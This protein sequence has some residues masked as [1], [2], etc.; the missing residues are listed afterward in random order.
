ML[1]RT[2]KKHDKY[3]EGNDNQENESDN[4]VPEQAGEGVSKTRFIKAVDELGEDQEDK[5]DDKYAS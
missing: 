1:E 5:I 3:E 2:K 4:V